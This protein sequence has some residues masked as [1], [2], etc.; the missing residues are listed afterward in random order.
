MNA[1]NALLG[2]LI[3]F[4]VSVGVSAYFASLLPDIVPTHWNVQGQIDHYGSKWTSLC[5]MPA[6]I[7]MIVALTIVL[8]LISPRSYEVTKSGIAYNQSMLLVTG[9]MGMIHVIIL[10]GTANAHIDMTRWLFSGIFVFFALLGNLMGKIKRNFFLGVRTPWTL[11]DERV[12]TE[13]H[14]VS[15]YQWFIG[16]VVGAI[17]SLVGVPIVVL[18][19]YLV[20]LSFLPVVTS[21][22][23]YKRLH[24]G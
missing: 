22:V 10:M 15:A 7:L 16:G 23:I 20:G 14:R 12:W 9:L 1:R 18:T 24:K 21:F 8:P 13:T 2:Q 6:V 11:A 17:L 4:A 3:I 19:T 5:A